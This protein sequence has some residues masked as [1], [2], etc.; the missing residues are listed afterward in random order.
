MKIIVLGGCGYVGTNLVLELLRLKYYVKVIDNRWFGN[1]LGKNKRLINIKKDI[2]NLTISDF[3]N[4]D[5]V[6]HL[7]NIAND[8]SVEL[9][10]ILSWEINV[11]SS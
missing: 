9:N 7:A 3:K 10:T 8:P 2:R 5:C 4:Y 1:F 6:I 11:L